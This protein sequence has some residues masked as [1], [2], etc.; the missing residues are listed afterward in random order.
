M[1]LAKALPL[2][3]SVLLGFTTIAAATEPDQVVRNYIDSFKQK[4]KQRMFACLDD[5]FFSEYKIKYLKTIEGYSQE[6]K[7]L[8]LQ[9]FEVGSVDA[10]QAMSGREILSKFLDKP[11]SD[12]Y[13]KGFDSIDLVIEAETLEKKDQRATVRSFLSAKGSAVKIETTYSLVRADDTWK[14]ERFQKRRVEPTKSSD[15]AAP[16]SSRSP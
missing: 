15:S 9:T 12:S 4:D 6:K 8:L 3:I 5:V 10:L 16:S 1:K 13:W 14:I 2:L 11:A 7:T